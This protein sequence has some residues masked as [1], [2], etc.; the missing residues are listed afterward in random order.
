MT[1]R[2]SLLAACGISVAV[3]GWASGGTAQILQDAVKAE[4]IV[5]MLVSPRTWL[6]NFP[7]STRGDVTA[8]SILRFEMRGF[9]LFVKI[10]FF[11][12]NV[13]CEKPVTVNAEGVA[14]DACLEPGYVFRFTPDDP[15]FA[16]R[17]GN[18][19]RWATLKPFARP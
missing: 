14:F 8:N 17:G 4:V 9:E 15:V 7:D 13:S 2:S 19:R 6:M 1:R 3:L 5:R 10:D 18:A 16:F 11:E 12:R